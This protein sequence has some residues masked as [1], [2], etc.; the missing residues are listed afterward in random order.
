MEWEQTLFQIDGDEFQNEYCTSDHSTQI[1]QEND[2]IKN[3]WCQFSKSG[4]IE[5]TRSHSNTWRF[6][7]SGFI[8]DVFERI[9]KIFQIRNCDA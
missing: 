5:H 9:V 4:E 2:Q 7:A 8:S 3:D 1:H 6:I